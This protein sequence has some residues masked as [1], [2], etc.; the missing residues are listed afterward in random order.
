MERACGDW[1]TPQ[2]RGV[3]VEVA[4]LSSIWTVGYT[5]PG[6]YHWMLQYYLRVQGLALSWVG[7]G[8]LI[9]SL[10]YDDAEFGAVV[11]RIVAAAVEMHADGWWRSP[12]SRADTSVGGYSRS[13]S[14][15]S[16]GRPRSGRARRGAACARFASGRISPRLESMCP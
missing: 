12:H 2:E 3:P 14:G 8:R 10:N 6:R 11:D 1:S 7:T 4:N 13:C 9:F 5:R 15:S 16:L